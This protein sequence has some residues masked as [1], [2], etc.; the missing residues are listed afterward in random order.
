MTTLLTQKYPLREKLS[1]DS[2][3]NAAAAAAR[4][5]IAE[6]IAELK[7]QGESRETM[8]S[9]LLDDASLSERDIIANVSTFVLAGSETTGHVMAWTPYILAE[10]A[11]VQER[12]RTDLLSLKQKG[13]V[14]YSSPLV[15]AIVREMLRLKTSTPQLGAECAV[16]QTL[17]TS[18]G[19]SVDI[20][21]GTLVISLF[22]EASLQEPL[23]KNA[24]AFD[25]YRWLTAD[26]A[27]LTVLQARQRPFGDGP[28]VCPGQNL[29]YLELQHFV[30][31][32]LCTFRASLV[33]GAPP[34]SEKLFFTSQPYGAVVILQNV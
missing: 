17:A 33:P 27:T 29:A 34:P 4:A 5:D 24:K 16:K 1:A 20:E 26:E 25:P 7:R 19:R 13:E 11:D 18:D 12:L 23:I 32:F 31:Q 2:A 8:L 22:R 21:P 15:L 3:E 6:L 14:L 30:A 10:N 9:A 28:R